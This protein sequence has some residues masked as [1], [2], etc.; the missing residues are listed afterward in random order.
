[1]LQ[2]IIGFGIIFAIVCAILAARGYKGRVHTVGIDLGTT[3]SVIVTDES[4]NRLFPSVVRF[5]PDDTIYNAKRFIGVSLEDDGVQSYADSHPFVVTA[6]SPLATGHPRL[7]SPE[8]VGSRVLQHL[9]S[10]TSSFLGHSQVNRAVVAVP[11]KFTTDQRRATVDAYKSVGLKVARVIEEP[12][13]AAVAYQLHKSEKVSRI[14]VYDFGGGTLDVSIL[15]VR[16]GIVE[17]YATDGDEHLGGS[18]FDLSVA[19]EISRL[20]E[21]NSGYSVPPEAELLKI[22]LS[23]AN[24]A[25]F[26]YMGGNRS[27]FETIISQDAFL[28]LTKPLFERAMLPV[29]RLLDEL[30]MSR[31]EIDEV[32]LVGGSTRIPRIKELLRE[33]FG[34]EL[35]DQ[36]DPDITVAYGAASIVD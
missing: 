19:E 14:L 21:E 25:S 35:N 4:G 18:D 22:V 28:E 13:A 33:Y 29:R 30:N 34:K 15:T 9:L 26:R 10:V 17:V 16:K 6:L 23:G 3:F 31:G 8:A 2:G 32:V 24:M 36:I 5:L 20:I 7:I 12:T 27:I 11:A 1:M